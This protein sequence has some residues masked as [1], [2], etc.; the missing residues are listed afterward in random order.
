MVSGVAVVHRT[1]PVQTPGNHCHLCHLFNFR[2]QILGSVFNVSRDEMIEI[3]CHHHR[4]CIRGRQSVSPNTATLLPAHKSI[5]VQF[6]YLA[7]TWSPATETPRISVVLPETCFGQFSRYLSVQ[8]ICKGLSQLRTPVDCIYY[9]VI[10]VD[11]L[12]WQWSSS[13][14]FPL[15]VGGCRRKVAD[16]N[17]VSVNKTSKPYITLQNGP[18]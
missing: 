14:H 16:N 8:I 15:Y 11:K 2:S 1:C 6:E 13:F 10:L 18:G 7:T 3:S 17:S 5:F 9:S 12:W 4:Q